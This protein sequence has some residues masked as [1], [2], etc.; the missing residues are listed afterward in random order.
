MF[1]RA[2]AIMKNLIPEQC[3]VNESVK[4]AV[5]GKGLTHAYTLEQ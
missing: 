1:K 4:T 5:Q 3:S 2:F